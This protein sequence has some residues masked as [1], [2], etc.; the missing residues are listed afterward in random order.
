[1]ARSHSR[2]IVSVLLAIAFLIWSGVITAAGSIG[3]LLNCSESSDECAAGLPSLLEPWTWDDFDV[4]PETLYLALVGLSAAALLVVLV[5]RGN[6]LF[7]AVALVS[8]LALLSYAFFAGL[9][10]EGEVKFVWGLVFGLGAVA[11]AT[12]RAGGT[13]SPS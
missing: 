5:V 4:F 7:S 12:R 2:R 13:R 10:T 8:S 11:T 9:T 1:M 3:A 6:R